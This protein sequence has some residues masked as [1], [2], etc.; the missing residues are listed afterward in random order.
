MWV[1]YFSRSL[2]KGE[3]LVNWRLY[4]YS[5]V[6]DEMVSLDIG[7]IVRG[8]TTI[9]DTKKVPYILDLSALGVIEG[10]SY[11]SETPTTPSE[12]YPYPKN[13]QKR[14][15]CHYFG[16]IPFALP[17]VGPYRFKR[18]R[19][20][21]ACYRYGTHA[22]P[23]RFNGGCGICPQPHADEKLWE[24]DCLQMNIWLPG[25]EPPKGGMILFLSI[26][27]LVFLISVMAKG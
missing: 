7:S 16:G 24:E 11:I 9:S 4:I 13:L 25:G 21:P 18:P 22:N 5:T 20:L 3:L 17:P 12:K 8:T 10:L 15:L 1:T 26:L 23:G 19:A 2:I 27:C 6:L 14:V